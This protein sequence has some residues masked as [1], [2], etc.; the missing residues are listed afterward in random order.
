MIDRGDIGNGS[1]A[2]IFFGDFRA[3]LKSEVGVS[4]HIVLV[5]AEDAHFRDAFSAQLRSPENARLC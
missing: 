5:S 4:T 1:A 2:T 3:G